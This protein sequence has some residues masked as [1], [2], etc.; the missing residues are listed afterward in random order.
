MGVCSK[1]LPFH[2]FEMEMETCTAVRYPMEVTNANFEQVLPVF[3]EDLKQADHVAIDCEFSGLQAAWHKRA[4]QVDSM[5]ERWTKTLQSVNAFQLMQFGVCTF[6]RS[7]TADGKARYVAT[8][9]NFYVFPHEWKYSGAKGKGR[10]RSIKDF[11]CQ[12]DSLEFLAE[13]SFDFNKWI[14]Q[15][16]DDRADVPHEIRH[17]LRL[18][19]G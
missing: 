7:S 12:S 15:G 2:T 6:R 13:H 16:M 5:Q 19:G 10:S 3:E 9:Y 18:V 11:L 8:P 14:Y 4:S 17:S 1:W